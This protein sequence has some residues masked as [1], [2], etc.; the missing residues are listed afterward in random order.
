MYPVACWKIELP[1]EPVPRTMKVMVS[2]HLSAERISPSS[3]MTGLKAMP[4]SQTVNVPVKV[5]GAVRQR[6]DLEC[7]TPLNAVVIW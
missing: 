3:L 2:T 1:S 5:P 4:P 6:P 7:S